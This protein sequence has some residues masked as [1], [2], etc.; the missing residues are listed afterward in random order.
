MPKFYC[1]SDVHGNYSAMKKA[2]DEAG[3][4]PT[5]ENHWLISLGDEFDRFE[6]NAKVLSYLRRLPRAVII[7]GNHIDLLEEC[8]ER[9]YP[10]GHDY[11]NGTMETV[12]ELGD[13][14]KGYS[15]Q[16]CCSRTLSKI[17]LYVDKMV[18]YFE[19]ANYIFVHSFIALKCNDSLPAYYTRN[20]HFEFDPEWRHANNSAWETARWGNPYELAEQGLL[21]EKTLVFGHFHTSWPRHKYEGKPEFGEGADFSIYYGDG[22]IALDACCAYSGKLNCLIIEDDF[23]GG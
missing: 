9:G 11:S 22:Y 17:H 5:N 4:D 3:F 18:D 6:E 19:T 15:F 1:I 2:L 8:C 23:I 12:C 7:K 20:R 10:Q 13:M 16:E 14:D 21:P